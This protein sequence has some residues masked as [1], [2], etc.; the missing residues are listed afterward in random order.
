MVPWSN[1]NVGRNKFKEHF[2]IRVR[3][4]DIEQNC[5]VSPYE[6]ERIVHQQRVNFFESGPL[7]KVIDE[8]FM[9]SADGTQKEHS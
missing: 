3:L 2:R 6:S 9:Q 8:A 7:S 5:R 1:D 4:E